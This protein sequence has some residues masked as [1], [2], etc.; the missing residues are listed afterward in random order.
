MLTSHPIPPEQVLAAV[1]SVAEQMR[2]RNRAMVA[3]LQLFNNRVFHEILTPVQV[4]LHA[5]GAAL[6]VNGP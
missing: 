6:H 2:A 5:R 4:C 1:D 3:N